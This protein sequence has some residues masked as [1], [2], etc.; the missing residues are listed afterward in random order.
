MTEELKIIIKAQTDQAQKNVKAAKEEVEKLGKEGKESGE[1]FKKAMETMK[2]VAKTAGKA[3]GTALK[4]VGTAVLAA[5]AA[6]VGLAESTKEYRAEQAKLTSAFETAGKTAD[7]AKS[8]Y[9]DLYRVLGDS[10]QAVEAANHLALLADNQEELSEWTNICQGVYATF[11]DSLPIEGLT[12]AANETAKVGQVTGSLADALNW[13]GVNED[14][15]NAKLAACNGEAEREALIRETLNGLYDDAAKNYEENAKGLLDANEAQARLTDSLAKMGEVVEPIVTILKSGLADVLEKITPHLETVSEGLQ[16]LFGGDTGGSKKIAD[17]ISSMLT[18]AVNAITEALPT[19]VRI[20]VDLISSLIKGI[21][22]AAPDI[23]KAL[24]QAI[25]LIVVELP[26]LVKMI[27]DMLPSLIR[28]LTDSLVSLIP[29]LITALVDIIVILCESFDSIIKPIIDSIPA[30]TI[31]II[32]GLMSNLDKLLGGLI[33]LILAIV[34]NIPYLIDSI[35]KALPTIISM[36]I[37]GLLSCLPQLIGGL[38]K[39]AWE[40]TKSLPSIL[41]SLLE[42]IVNIFKGVWDGLSKVFAKVGSWFKEKFSGASDGIKSAFSGIGDW[43]KGIWD[44]IKNAFA[45]VKDWFKNIFSSAWEA[46][47]N[48]FSGVGSF[49][50]NIWNTIKA[51]FSAIGQKVGGAISDAFK[52]AINWILEKAVGLINGFIKSI[53]W[54]IGVINKIPGVNISQINLLNVPKLEQGGVLKKGQVGL[55]EGNGAEAVVPLEKNTGWLDKIAERLNGSM[56]GQPIILQVDGKTFAQIAC[57]S[58]ND[59]TRQ[60]GSLPLALG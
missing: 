45:A 3:I 10:G 53:N 19:I 43:F 6:L 57:A 47:K 26:N 29:T 32:E 33:T 59:L 55:L 51:Q 37:D 46:I 38:I 12:E 17:G 25:E 7:E 8:T 34:Q 9:N 14:D 2:N 41:G 16:A 11:G 35:V 40:I 50:A 58:I 31:A 49:F 20:G 52:T 42:G 1:K 30:I 21:L 28:Q 54:A 48:V 5:G 18:D 44:K 56:G 39:I 4:A 22:Q 60:T 13:A 36:I 15:F 27:V 23:I 24:A